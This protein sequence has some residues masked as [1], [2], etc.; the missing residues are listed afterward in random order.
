MALMRLKGIEDRVYV[1]VAGGAKVWAI[2]DEERGSAV[3]LSPIPIRHFA[4]DR[5]RRAGAEIARP[6][7]FGGL[8]AAR[9]G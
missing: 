8:R 2:A 7:P 1:A 9:R 4:V 5:R 3:R 6:A